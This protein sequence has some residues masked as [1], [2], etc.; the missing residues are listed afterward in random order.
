MI[1]SKEIPLAGQRDKLT[2]VGKVAFSFLA[3]GLLF[4]LWVSVQWG[5]NYLIR[6]ANFTDPIDLFMFRAVQ[7]LFGLGSLWKVGAYIAHDIYTEIQQYR[8]LPKAEQPPEVG[9]LLDAE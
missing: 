8:Q 2:E 4:A 6:Q 7:I 5:V 9:Q 3:D 1:C